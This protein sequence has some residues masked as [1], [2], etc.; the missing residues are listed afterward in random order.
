MPLRGRDWYMARVKN[1]LTQF[2]SAVNDAIG[3]EA[4]NLQTASMLIVPVDS[5]RLKNSCTCVPVGTEE[6]PRWRVAY[7]TDYAFYVHE[8]VDLKHA[9][10]KQAKYLEDPLN[11]MKTTYVQNLWRRSS[12][13]LRAAGWTSK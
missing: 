2:P 5:S 13:N 12:A 1:M 9:E 6:S 4:Y 10:G 8:R 11:A 7:G 3:A